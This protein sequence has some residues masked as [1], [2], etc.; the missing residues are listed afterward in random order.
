MST[1]V[2]STTTFVKIEREQFDNVLRVGTPEFIARIAS[3]NED[4]LSRA[5]RWANELRSQKA[6]DTYL[7]FPVRKEKQ[8]AAGVLYLKALA[9]FRSALRAERAARTHTTLFS[10][11]EAEGVVAAA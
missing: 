3:F 10:N 2:Q 5:E 4:E 7:T 8:Q 9:A 6:K 11:S 1:E